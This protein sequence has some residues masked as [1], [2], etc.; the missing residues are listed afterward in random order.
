VERQISAYGNYFLAFYEKQD[1][2]TKDKID[3]V[4]D[5]VKHVR[6][7]PIKFLKH[8]EGTDGLYEIRVSTSNKIIRIFCFFDSG[9]LVILTN[10]FIKKTQ[11]TPRKELKLALRL[12]QEYFDNKNKK[13]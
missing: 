4:L 13:K 11:K 7:V 6:Q 9:R 5:L 8:L 1:S 12:M 2:K 10:C 3:Y